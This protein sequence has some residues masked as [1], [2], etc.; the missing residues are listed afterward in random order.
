MRAASRC[1]RSSS[2]APGPAGLLDA[3]RHLTLLQIDPVAAIAPSADLV[4][5]SRLGSA[6]S[7]AELDAAL[8]NRT[9]LE[10]RAMI[11]PA[12]DLALYRADMAALGVGRARR[13]RPAGGRFNRD[14]VRANDAC[15]RDILDRLGVVGAAVV[16]R[17]SRHLHG[18]VAVD[19][20]D[21]QPQ[22]H[23]A[24]GLHGVARRG[25]RRGT[26]RRR[27]AVGPGQRGSTPMTRSS[28]RTRRCASATSGG[29]APWASPAPAVRN[30]RSSRP[31]WA[32]SASRPW[33]RGSRARG[34]LTRPSSASRS[35]GARRCCLPS[36]GS[37]TTASAPSSCLSSTT[38][39]RCTSPSA[40]RRWGYFALPILYG[41]RL[42]GKLDAD[43]R[44]P[45]RRPAGPRHPPGRA[46][47]QGRDRGRRSRDQRSG[48]LARPGARA[49]RLRPSPSP[50]ACRPYQI[51]IYYPRLLFS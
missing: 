36:T 26:P 4:A 20:L 50:A 21:Q 37:S 8:E 12:E 34:G 38:S 11:R 2:T 16:P 25:R 24:A 13:I 9:L 46:V 28:P 22:R 49:T 27:S 29:C 15:R 48:P 19:G 14:W 42:V 45:V 10:L 30:A 1:A 7:P 43:G 18:A 5:W 3:V 31:T 41:D 51:G 44:P 23:Q 47:H 33:S 17:A 35:R 32:R 40:K 6:Y 39:W